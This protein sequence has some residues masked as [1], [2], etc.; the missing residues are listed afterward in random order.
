[1]LQDRLAVNLLLRPTSPC[2][3]KFESFSLL[4][5]VC[6]DFSGRLDYSS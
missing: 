4:W 2:A 1:V 3:L 6:R 5:F